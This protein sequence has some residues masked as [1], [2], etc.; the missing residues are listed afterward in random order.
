[1]SSIAE[2]QIDI[3]KI[4]TDMFNRTVVDSRGKYIYDSKCCD[5]YN[6][7]HEWK[8]HNIGSTDSDFNDV[9]K[10][11]QEAISR[12]KSAPSDVD[13]IYKASVSSVSSV[14]S[15]LKNIYEYISVKKN[16]DPLLLKIEK[17]IEFDLYLIAAATIKAEAEYE[18]KGNVTI[19]EKF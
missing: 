5:L 7:I 3:D 14:I 11:I 2:F 16:D 15:M 4:T 1:L 19:V 12:R 18:D 6:E 8:I 9:M 17:A 13:Y 10:R